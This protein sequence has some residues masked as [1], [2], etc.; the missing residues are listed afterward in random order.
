MPGLA[1]VTGLADLADDVVVSVPG[2]A[3]TDS[4]ARF[5]TASRDLVSM[6]RTAELP[7]RYRPRGMI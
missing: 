4:L 3:D 6:A 2:L 1:V 7:K 5:D